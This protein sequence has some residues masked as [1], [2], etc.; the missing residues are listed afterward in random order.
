[1]CWREANKRP[2]TFNKL[3][4]TEQLANNQD[5]HIIL[6]DVQLNYPPSLDFSENMS[7]KS[8]Y[9]RILK[10][11]VLSVVG[12]TVIA[13]FVSG[14]FFAA[15]VSAG[16]ISLPLILS[17]ACVLMCAKYKTVI[18]FVLYGACNGV[19]VA[20]LVLEVYFLQL[21]FQNILAQ[22]GLGPG[23]GYWLLFTWGGGATASTAGATLGAFLACIYALIRSKS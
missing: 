16:L 21:H 5:T 3:K 13:F 6:V 17:Y 4:Y 19:F 10:Y 23:E 7:G 15:P 18:G 2:P 14:E 22:K 8:R 9:H 1:M 20:N 12:F 11:I